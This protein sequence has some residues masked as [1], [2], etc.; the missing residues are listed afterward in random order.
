VVDA[1]E[2]HAQSLEAADLTGATLATALRERARGVAG[3]GVRGLGLGVAHDVEVH[4]DR[5][6]FLVLCRSRCVGRP[7][8]IAVARSP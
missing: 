3:L 6:G 4:V 5:G 8:L 7:V 2:R 1:I